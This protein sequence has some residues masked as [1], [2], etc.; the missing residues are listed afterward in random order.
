MDCFLDTAVSSIIVA[1]L[2][3]TLFLADTLKSYDVSFFKPLISIEVV[4]A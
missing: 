3:P 4:P 2:A 1:L